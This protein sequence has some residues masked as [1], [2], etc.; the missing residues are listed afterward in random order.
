M[1]PAPIA[2]TVGKS[3]FKIDVRLYQDGRFGFEYTPNNGKRFRVRSKQIEDAISRATELIHMGRAGTVD[4][5]G[6]SRDDFAKFLRWQA[7]Q[8]KSKPVPDLVD[9]LLLSKKDKGRSYSHLATLE[10]TLKS[11]ARRFTCS[12]DELRREEVESWLNDKNVAPRTWNNQ[13]ER[14]LSLFSFARREGYIGDSKTPIERIEKQSVTNKIGIYTPDEL[15][16]ILRVVSNEW[17]PMIVLGAFAG[18]RP[19]EICPDP[20]SSKPPLVWDNILWKRAIIDV[21]TEVA[22]QRRR[23]FVPMCDALLAFLAPFRR[24]TGPVAPRMPA[25][26]MSQKCSKDSGIPWIR[27]GLRHSYASYR[28]PLLKDVHKLSHEMGN[29]PN[30]CHS[31]YLQLKFEEEANEWFAIRPDPRVE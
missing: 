9:A 11:F 22:K 28:L 29:S 1:K 30:I 4:L 27:D 18:L 12:I 13:L 26:R 31:H 7:T 10:H 8:V 14:I 24:A 15:R 17:L 20:R 19:E 2:K 23:R 16:K 6:A 21:P 3:G 5:L 25:T